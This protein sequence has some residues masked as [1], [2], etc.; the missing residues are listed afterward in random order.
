EFI[1]R[2]YAYVAR[3]YLANG[4]NTDALRL[5]REGLANSPNAPDLYLARGVITEL[6][7]IRQFPD[8]RSPPPDWDD[9]WRRNEAA[10]A[11]IAGL[12]ESAAAD[13]RR[14]IG[15]NP[16][17]TAAHVRL[18]WVHFLERDGRAPTDLSPSLSE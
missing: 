12:L 8:L 18:G 5:V 1:P 17:F 4:R 7:V 3:M 10:R 14:A 15:L 9:V 11:R 6:Q 16:S 2:W 13:Y